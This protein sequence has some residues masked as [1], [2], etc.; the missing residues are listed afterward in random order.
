M[1]TAGED[2]SRNGDKQ[3]GNGGW[4]ATLTRIII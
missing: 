2:E 1:E 4:F 3:K